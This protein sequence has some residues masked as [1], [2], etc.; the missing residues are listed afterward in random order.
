MNQQLI[1]TYIQAYKNKFASISKI[2][3][4]KWQAVKQFQ[5][6]WDIDAE[7]FH[8][9]AKTALSKVK[10][11]MDAGKYFPKRMLLRNAEVAP[12]EVRQLFKELFYEDE[13]EN[14]GIVERITTFQE[15]FKALSTENFNEK[16]HYQDHRAIIVYLTLKYPNGHF[17]YKFGMFN[18]FAAKIDYTYK[19]VKGH[20]ENVNHFE[21][22][23]ENVKYLI[24]QDQELLRLHNNRLTEDC[25]IDE[26]LNILTQ[27][28]IYAV[29]EHL[30][31]K[32]INPVVIEIENPIQR[33]LSSAVSVTTSNVSFNVS[34]INHIQNSK[35]NKRIGDLG[36]LFVMQLERG[37]LIN[38]NKPKLAKKVAHHAIDK[39]DGL[40]Y[41]VL[42]FDEK[43]NE[44]FIEVKSTK[45]SKNTPFYITRNELERSKQEQE[46]YFIYRIYNF[47]DELIKGDVLVMQGDVSDLCIEAVNYKVKMLQI[48]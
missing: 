13:D 1:Q 5:D 24:S 37:K 23:C 29:V 27:D 8:G 31:T 40:G 22:L 4:Y 11:L 20:I 18:G 7:D 45:G 46:K 28:F 39:G 33:I 19:P 16:N 43:G 15:K 48:E 42:S 47:N 32:V 35:E 44:M 12:E 3:L 38:A 36:E 25:Y 6:N 2:E 14:I 26:S 9:M 17:F 41:D 10:N 30:D 21:R 34:I